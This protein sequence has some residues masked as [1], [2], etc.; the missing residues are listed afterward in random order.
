[1]L[2]RLLNFV[3]NRLPFVKKFDGHKTKLA[4]VLVAFAALVVAFSH[5]IPAPY[6]VYAISIAQLLE[7]MAGVL[8]TVGVAGML[9]KKWDIPKFPSK[10]K[11]EV[12]EVIER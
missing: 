6:D 2:I 3:I 8:G 4:G 7:Q 1:M 12:P 9:V 11:P 10:E 5:F